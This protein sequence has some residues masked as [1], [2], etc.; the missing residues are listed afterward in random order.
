MYLDEQRR[1]REPIMPKLRALAGGGA[2]KPPALY[3]DVKRELG[4]PILH[5]YGMTEV[6]MIS[7]GRF[8]HTDE[9]LAYTDGTPVDGAEVQIID[10]EICVRGPVVC[11][12]YTDPARTAEAFDADGFF[13][14]GD[15]GHLRADGHLVVTGRLK[16]VIIRKGE[17]ISAREIEDVLVTHPKVHDV[18]VIGLPD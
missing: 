1:S 12:G 13:H 18:A 14:T 8:E 7:M 3:D 9:Q 16:D 5:G 2:A 10:G 15:L 6:P 11:H 4:I 17:N